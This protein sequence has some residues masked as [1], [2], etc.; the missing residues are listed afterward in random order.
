MPNETA[1]RV[2]ELIA[3][4]SRVERESETVYLALGRL[5]P[6]LFEEMQR[7][8]DQAERSLK[9][10]GTFLEESAAER[11]AERRADGQDI[12]D[13]RGFVQ[14]SSVF[15]RSMHE[16]DKAFLSRINESIDHLGSLDSVILRVRLDS[17]EM[18][19]IS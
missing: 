18:E 9:G 11:R 8:A 13:M 7:S 14:E 15:F 12:R 6:R 16:R 4:C 19:I 3:E 10:F 5:F 2:S 1:D 17:E